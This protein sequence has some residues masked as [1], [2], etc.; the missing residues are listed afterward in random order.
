M[1]DMGT[2]F[3][4][5]LFVNKKIEQLHNTKQIFNICLIWTNHNQI[6]INEND[7]KYRQYMHKI[8]LYLINFYFFKILKHG[9]S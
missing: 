6:G 7:V 3:I 4:M 5:I 8:K 1:D 2:I 9:I